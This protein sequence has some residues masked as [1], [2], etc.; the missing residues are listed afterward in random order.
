M[1]GVD[2]NNKKT[3][4]FHKKEEKRKECCFKTVPCTDFG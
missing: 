2:E 4:A 1:L 3:Q